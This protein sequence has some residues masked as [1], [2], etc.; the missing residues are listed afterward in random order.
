MSATTNGVISSPAPWLD[1]S[2]KETVKATTK[3]ELGKDEFLKI[4]LT[5]LKYQDP[6]EPMQDKEFIAQMASFS[7]LEQMTNLNTGFNSLSKNI[8]ENLLPNLMLQ[9]STNLIGKQVSYLNTKN[10]NGTTSTE[11]LT[12][13]I[14]SVILKQ[15]IPYYVIDDKEVA[16]SK[17]TKIMQGGLLDISD[18]ILLEILDTLDQLKEL[19][20]PEE[21]EEP[22]ESGEGEADGQ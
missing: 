18:E 5:Q 1:N 9:Q 17:V 12:G 21:T 8:N 3:N 11:T 7:A 4:L 2:N 15:G 19:L 16:M 22:G 6:L 20:S 10:S 14:Q 13:T